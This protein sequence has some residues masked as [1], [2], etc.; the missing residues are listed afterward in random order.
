MLLPIA[1]VKGSKLPA[2]RLPKLSQQNIL[3]RFLLGV[4]PSAQHVCQPVPGD[5]AHDDEIILLRSVCAVATTKLHW[6]RNGFV[7]TNSRVL[8]LHS[9][10][11]LSLRWH[12]TSDSLTLHQLQHQV[13]AL[14][15]HEPNAFIEASCKALDGFN[16]GETSQF[17]G[18]L[19]AQPGFGWV[20]NIVLQ[21]QIATV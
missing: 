17:L 4:V 20:E 1:L 2:Q 13:F 8:L 5:F 15:V 6:K 9:F 18:Q 21:N 16:A 10:Q 11:V 19:G 12:M 7:S 3:R 14:A